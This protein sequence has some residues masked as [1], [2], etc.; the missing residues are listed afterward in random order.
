MNTQQH[1]IYL[2]HSLAKAYNALNMMKFASTTYEQ[3]NTLKSFLVIYT[4]GYY[5]L[6]ANL[7][8]L[9]D[10]TRTTRNL[11]RCLSSRNYPEN[12]R[13]QN[14]NL[15]NTLKT[16]HQDALNQLDNV[17]DNA[18]AHLSANIDELELR[19]NSMAL[20]LLTRDLFEFFR[21]I[22]GFNID[23]SEPLI[24]DYFPKYMMN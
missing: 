17:R 22:R 11:E 8:V 6:Y 20:Q 3:N 10:N 4:D 23:L 2:Y 19:Q 9:F 16:A 12:D 13:Q 18:T 14:L 21:N 7:S 24:L 5:S 1:L 15:Y